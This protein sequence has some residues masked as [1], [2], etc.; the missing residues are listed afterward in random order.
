[1]LR[2]SRAGGFEL[3]ASGIGGVPPRRP[4]LYALGLEDAGGALGA[5]QA[6]C[7]SGSTPPASTS[8]RSAV[9][10]P[11]HACAGQAQRA[12]P[13]LDEPPALPEELTRAVR[14]GARDAV[15]VHAARRG[16]RCTTPPG[17]RCED[18]NACCLAGGV[19]AMLGSC[20][21]AGCC[22]GG[23]RGGIACGSRLRAAS[24]ESS[25]DTC[26]GLSEL[27]DAARDAARVGGAGGDF[28]YG[29]GPEYKVG[30]GRHAE[31]PDGDDNDWK[32]AATAEAAARTPP[33]RRELNGI[34]GARVVDP[35]PTAATAWQTTTGRP[36]VTIAV[37]DSGI[38]WNDA[39]RD[40]R[41]APQD[42]PEQG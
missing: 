39:R 32:Y 6:A 38:K 1:M 12:L 4:R 30:P 31:R 22:L 29:T 3:R 21:G 25:R 11:R 27:S 10:G 41:P 16:A 17:G 28:P 26:G 42:A 14:P 36:D 5:W 8:P 33:T 20:A 7:R 15:P 40:A 24:G 13:R 2:A 35:S 34:R 23:N 19:R 9:L 18:E 37:L